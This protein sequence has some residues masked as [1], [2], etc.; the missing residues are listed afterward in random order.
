MGAAAFVSDLTTIIYEKPDTNFTILEQQYLSEIKNLTFDLNQTRSMLTKSEN[1]NN[2]LR[3]QIVELEIEVENLKNDKK[4]QED[5]LFTSSENSV[6]NSVPVE[7][8]ISTDQLE[9]LARI[10]LENAKLKEERESL[11]M[12]NI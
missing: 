9:E 11:V 7:N 6:P 8:S 10:K 12:S 2:R 3:E 1:F 5:N 4:I